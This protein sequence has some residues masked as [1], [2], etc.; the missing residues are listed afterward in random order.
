MKHASLC[1]STTQGGGKLGHEATNCAPLAAPILFGL[2]LHRCRSRVLDLEPMNGP[3]GSIGRAEPFYTEAHILGTFEAAGI[4][5]SKAARR[6]AQLAPELTRD[7]WKDLYEWLTR[8]ML[9]DGSPD[10]RREV[11]A[12]LETCPCCD[13]WLGQNRPRAV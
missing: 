3:T 4:K 1:S 2:A 13:R 10:E 6:V 8:E 11:L 9:I 5:P 7:E 12:T